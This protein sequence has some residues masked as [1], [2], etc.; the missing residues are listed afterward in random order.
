M[1]GRDGRD[2]RG[3]RADDD[4]DE[5]SGRRGMRGG[6]GGSGLGSERRTGGQG[7]EGPAGESPRCHLVHPSVCALRSLSRTFPFGIWGGTDSWKWKG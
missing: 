1:N 7:R 4:D 2:G 3:R 5:R 6:G